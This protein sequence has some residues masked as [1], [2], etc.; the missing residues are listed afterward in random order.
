MNE[1]FD[2][3]KYYIAAEKTCNMIFTIEQ[4]LEFMKE[5]CVKPDDEVKKALIPMVEDLKSWLD[6]KI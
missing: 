5:Y 1:D 4:T 6:D 2:G 3:M